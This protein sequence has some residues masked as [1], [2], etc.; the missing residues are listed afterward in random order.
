MQWTGK[1]LQY[2]FKPIKICPVNQLYMLLL[3]L[4]SASM[5]KKIFL[6]NY[7]NRDSSPKREHLPSL[8]W[9]WVFI[10]VYLYNICK[11]GK[12]N[13]KEVN[14]YRYSVFYQISSFVFKKRNTFDTFS[15][16]EGWVNGDKFSIFRWT[17]PLIGRFVQ[18]KLH[19]PWCFTNIPPISVIASKEHYKKKH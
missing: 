19:Y 11:V 5:Q 2:L 14:G 10:N 8:M 18:K 7:V 6:N 9:L 13:F 17:I 15:T 3:D 12:T 16:C 4:L 1:K